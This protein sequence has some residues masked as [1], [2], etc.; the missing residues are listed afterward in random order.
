MCV[1]DVE[2]ETDARRV[3]TIA[4][5]AA[6]AWEVAK[7]DG[8]TSSSLPSL[9]VQRT[10]EAAIDAARHLDDWSGA[11]LR[12]QREQPRAIFTRTNR[13]G[14][15]RQRVVHQ[16]PDHAAHDHLRQHCLAERVGVRN[17]LDLQRTHRRP[18]VESR[19]LQCS[20]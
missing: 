14:A 15:A 6:G 12:G 9:N 7:F 3:T 17:E 8:L 18:I 13:H 1:R 19:Q 2:N 11:P 4:N 16:S 5:T 10:D 20:V